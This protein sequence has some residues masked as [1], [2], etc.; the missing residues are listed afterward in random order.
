[1]NLLLLLAA[2]MRIMWISGR[3]AAPSTVSPNTAAA[4]RR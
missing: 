1:M 3:N 4:E 2:L